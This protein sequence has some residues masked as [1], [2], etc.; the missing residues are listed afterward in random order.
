MQAM[1]YETF[2]EP[3]PAIPAKDDLISAELMINTDKCDSSVLDLIFYYS[4]RVDFVVWEID[5]EG[6]YA[7]LFLTGE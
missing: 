4:W 6:Y 2:I 5:A 1:D 3:M 7:K